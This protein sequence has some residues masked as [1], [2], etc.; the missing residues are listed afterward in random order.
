MIMV[1][2]ELEICWDFF[3]RDV[4]A[5]KIRKFALKITIRL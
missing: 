1:V 5:H 4:T 3:T 2:S